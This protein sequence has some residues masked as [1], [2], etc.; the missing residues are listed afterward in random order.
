MTIAGRINALVIAILLSM[1]LLVSGFAS[2]REYRLERDRL[3]TQLREEATHRPDLAFYLYFDNQQALAST[4]ARLIE[5]PSVASA[6]VRS[7]GGSAMLQLPSGAA[8]GAPKL[9]FLRQG[10]SEADNGLVSLDG[11]GREVSGGLLGALLGA[12]RNF[13]LTLPITSPVNPLASRVSQREFLAAAAQP[14]EAKVRH[15]MGYLQLAVNQRAL[16]R[17]V[18]PGILL[19]VIACLAFALLCLAFSL[20][21]TRRITAPIS[22]L[23]RLADGIASGQMQEPLKVSGGGEVEEIANIL[24]G[25]VTG[26][27]KYKREMDVDHQLLSMKVEERTSQLSRR[28]AELNKAVEQ[29][30]RTKNRL[31]QMAY[32]DSLTSLPNRRLFTEQLSLLLKLSQRNSQMLAL[33][34]LDLDNFKRINDSL[35]HSAGDLLLREVGQRLSRCVR[36]SDVVAHYVDPSAKID[37]SRLGGDEFTVVLNQIETSESAALVAQRLITALTEPMLINGHELV[38]TPSIGIALAPDHATDVEGLLRCADTAM[39]RAKSTGKSSHLFYDVSMED[40]G[41]DRLT[42]ENDLRKAMDNNELVLFYQPQVDT[43][44]GKVV[45]AEALL[46]WQHPEQGLIPPFRF[47][48]LAEEMGLIGEMG[49]WVIR[50]ACRQVKAFEDRGIHLPKVAVNVSALQFTPSFTRRVKAMLDEIGVDPSVL[51][52]ELTEGVV[53]GDTSASIKALAELRDLGVSLSIDDFGTGYSSLSY[54][55]RFP[56]DE[57][58]ID[59]S[60]VIGATSS[61]EDASLVR[62]IVAMAK[63]LGLKLVAEGVETDQQ[64]AFMTDEGAHVIQGYMFSKPVSAEELEPLLAPW[65]FLEQIKQLETRLQR[66]APAARIS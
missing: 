28:N 55:S 24:N 1:S 18:L 61:P 66:D 20:S 44:S 3:L 25:V 53:M 16:L 46:R 47:I 29:V 27:S 23:A 52:L 62:A 59:R 45:G 2:V 35:G 22:R 63:G 7:V 43:H 21:L 39:Y 15:V 57:L 58:K 26:I 14:R 31:R 60:F 10:L 6:I 48:P 40:E 30:T 9:E 33:L 42:L 65:H 50:E 11:R 8:A 13:Q 32:Y 17:E 12:D 56:L 54:L 38:V 36:D 19:V 49:D 34:F 37:V 41:L 5:P 64:Y 4:L 51:E